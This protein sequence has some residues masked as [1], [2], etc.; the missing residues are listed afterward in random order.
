ML[1]KSQCL[2]PRP[3]IRAV[4]RWSRCLERGARGIRPQHNPFTFSGS[5]PVLPM[6]PSESHPHADQRGT[7]ETEVRSDEGPIRIRRSATGDYAVR[8]QSPASPTGKTTVSGQNIQR[9][10]AL[11]VG[12]LSEYVAIRAVLDPT[13]PDRWIPLW[14]SG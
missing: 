8:V 9:N 6:A 13:P 10:L 14:R 2:P 11:Q 5:V 3:A 7:L 12:T 4:S 1:N